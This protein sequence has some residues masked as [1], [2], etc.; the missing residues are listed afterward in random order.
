M[1]R[2]V[3]ALLAAVVLAALAAAPAPASQPLP[4]AGV[5][6]RGTPASHMGTTFAAIGRRGFGRRTSPRRTSPYSRRPYRRSPGFGHLMGNVLKFLGIAYLVN[7]LFG[8]GPGGG[9]PLGLLIIVAVV[10]YLF[11]RRRA[12]RRDRYGYAH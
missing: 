7:A 9:S 8:W 1:S 11:G 3:V 2:A 6:F 10:A 12:R 5:A 4:A